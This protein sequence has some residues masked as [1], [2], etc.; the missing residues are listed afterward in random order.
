MPVGGLALRSG[1]YQRARALDRASVIL[2]GGDFVPAPGDSLVEERAALMIEAMNLMD[3]DAVG[4][5]E[6]EL[7]LGP[8]FLAR[9]AGR[10]PL[11]CANVRVPPGLRSRIPPVRWLDR[12]GR[13]IAVTGYVDPL[14]YYT[15]PGAIDRS[16]D[17]LLVTDPIQALTPVM[18]G[19]RGKADF[20]V[21]LGHGDTDE[22]E[23]WLDAVPGATVLVQGHRPP[24]AHGVSMIDGTYV[25]RAGPSSRAVAQLELRYQGPDSLTA[26]DYRLIDLRREQRGDSRLDDMV[27]A[28]EK[29]YGIREQ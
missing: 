27:L 17:S 16:P 29:K 13:R 15:L 24:A 14:L 1:V 19:L 7:M 5:G 18:A 12:D 22:V 9:A 3:Y 4:L 2:D 25:L 20:V 28:F 10:L 23:E 6:D 11:V 8:E 26:V 21:V